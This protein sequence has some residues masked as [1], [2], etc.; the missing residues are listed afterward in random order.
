MAKV[1]YCRDAG[2]DCG[3]VVRGQTV[4][5]IMKAAAE[6]GKQVHNLEVTPQ[7]AEQLK[8]LIRD[9]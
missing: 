6:H 2:F 8:G 3:A 1:L 7:L 5:E 4:D 9:E